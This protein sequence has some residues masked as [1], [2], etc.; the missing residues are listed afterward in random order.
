[1]KYLNQRQKVLAQNISN[2][3]TPNYRPLDLQKVNFGKVLENVRKGEQLSM[4]STSPGHMPAKGEVP[5]AKAKVSK[6]LYEVAPDSNGVI[7]EEQLMKANQT[8][9][10]YDL[11]LNL[12]KSN[13]EMMK[14]AMAKPGGR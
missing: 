12:Y 3:D 7:L 10:D 2:A 14:T 5:A 13:V 6:E 11:M 8:Q 9:M 4:E 1:M